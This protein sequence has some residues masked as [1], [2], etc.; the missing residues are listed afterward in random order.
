MILRI[1]SVYILAA[2]ILHSLL[3]MMPLWQGSTEAGNY[4]FKKVTVHALQ[5]TIVEKADATA[6]EKSEEQTSAINKAILALN[7][8]TILSSFI[9]IFLFK[10]RLRQLMVSRFLML[11]SSGLI[12]LLYFNSD[13]GKDYFA[14][15][16]FSSSFMAGEFFPIAT[17]IL[18]F[19]AGRAILAD[20]KLVRSA[21][22]LR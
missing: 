16:K 1:Q 10:I 2:I 13:H 6:N 14:G 19:L 20:E 12:F 17:L 7:G 3:F 5:T 8:F 18:F 9:C 21:D 22:R 11:L 4:P 15:I